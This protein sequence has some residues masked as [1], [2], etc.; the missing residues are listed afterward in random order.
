MC[1]RASPCLP[2][3][4]CLPPPASFACCRGNLT[5]PWN[6]YNLCA[7]NST[8][9][10]TTPRGAGYAI[11]VSYEQDGSVRYSHIMIMMNDNPVSAHPPRC[12]YSLHPPW[13]PLLYQLSHTT[14]SHLRLLMC[15][16]SPLTHI[17]LL[18]LHPCCTTLRIPLLLHHF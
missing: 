7:F 16:I 5:V 14:R 11:T 10:Q 3:P 8:S 4:R 2:H 9:Q 6:L 13:H 18:R 15:R 12:A 1:M 17:P